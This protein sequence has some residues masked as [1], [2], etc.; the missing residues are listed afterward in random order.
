V[1]REPAGRKRDCPLPSRRVHSSPPMRICPDDFSRLVRL[2]VLGEGPRGG[3][4]THRDRQR[5]EGREH[6]QIAGSRGLFLTGGDGRDALRRL[7]IRFPSGSVGSTPTFDI[8]AL[9]APVD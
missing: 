5:R 4:R 1:S 8:R 9:P 3:H 6:A 7:K 2:D